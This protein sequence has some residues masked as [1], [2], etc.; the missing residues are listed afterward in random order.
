[1]ATAQEIYNAM[2]F[3]VKYKDEDIYKY[4]IASCDRS[5]GLMDDIDRDLV[6]G[7]IEEFNEHEESGL[8][9][10]DFDNYLA[11]IKSDTHKAQAKAA[12]SIRKSNGK[13]EGIKAEIASVFE[14]FE[15]FDKEEDLNL[16]S[17]PIDSLPDAVS[18]CVQ[19]VSESVQ[20]SEEMAACQALGVLALCCQ[21]LFEINIKPDWT[22]PVNLYL[23]EMARPSERKSPTLKQMVQPIYDYMQ[24]YNEANAD[25]I[26]ASES[27][28]RILKKQIESIEKNLGSLKSA[29]KGKLQDSPG[30]SDV[31]FDFDDEVE[32]QDTGFT[33]NDLMEKQKELRE[34]ESNAKRKLLLLADDITPESIS[35]VMQTQRERLGVMTAEGGLFEIL[36]G[37]YSKGDANIDVVLK[38]YSGE[39]YQSSRIGR[40]SVSLHK[41]LLTLTMAVQPIV[42]SKIM[43]NETFKGRGF[44]AR[45]LYSIPAS[46]V[47]SRSFKTNPIGERNRAYCKMIRTILNHSLARMEPIKLI[48]TDEALKATEDFYQEVEGRLLDDLEEVEEW[49]GKLVGNTM[50]I[51]AL[52]HVASEWINTN[53]TE[54]SADTVQ[55]AISIGRYFIEHS[56]AA[57]S[58][59]GMN[60]EPAVKDAKYIFKRMTNKINDLNDFITG[61]DL[62]RLCQRFK[63]VEDMEPG[64]LELY[65]HGYIRMEKV[66]TGKRGRPGQRY[67]INPEAFFETN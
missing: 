30:R 9:V 47:G 36:S 55:K 50:R 58:M 51:A 46:K 67:Y 20:V 5:C 23:L 28:I 2:P 6:L 60:E 32:D 42:I 43:E 48:L 57:F 1:M 61:M 15:P 64:L 56:R 22:E 16:P 12:E 40:A 39:P 41:P 19:A 7:I 65:K 45:F 26:A 44:L 11:K 59:A 33:M 3:T 18:S 25:E 24:N 10:E 35:V 4:I 49:A 8:N 14:P 63:K 52:I 27:R 54:V 66:D 31:P 53:G 62:K 13:N 21:G 38:S 29:R 17:F 37:M 34:A